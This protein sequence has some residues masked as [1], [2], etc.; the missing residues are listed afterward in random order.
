MTPAVPR[1]LSA[2]SSDPG[3]V[4]D[5]NE[6][7][8]Y[9]DDTRGFFVVIDGMGGHQA[10]EQA[11]DIALERIRSRLE[12]QT[13]NAEQRL[14][15]AITLANNAIFEAAH[16]REEWHGMAC[17]LTA[18]IVENGHV[19]IG[20]VGDSR[21][22]KIR[23]G[24]IEKMT[25]DHSPVGEREDRGEISEAEAM[26]HPRRNEVYR[27]V[28]SM[29]HAPDD[30]DFIEIARIPFE[31]DSAL[32][33]CSDGLSDV[34]SSAAI[35]RIVEAN[36]GDRW[37]A[38]RSLIAAANEDGKDNISAILVE[39]AEYASGKPIRKDIE[40]TG[41]I[42][43]VR[44]DA[45]YRR[46]GYFAAGLILGGLLV[47]A[48]QSMYPPP[49]L[50]HMPQSFVVAEDGTIAAALIKAQAGDTVLLPP[51][52][53]R[54]LVE[55]KAGVDLIAQKPRETILEGSLVA[56]SI[57]HVR[58]ENLQIRAG[59]IGIDIRNSDVQI[60]RCEVSGAHTAGVRFSGNSSGSLIASVIRNNPGAGIAIEDASAPAIEH[61]T[62]TANG[63]E[64][65]A[66]H[67]GLFIHTTGHPAVHGN[68]F[69]GNGAEAI[70]L[71][72]ADEGIVQRNYFTPAS[73][74]DKRKPFRIL[75]PEGRP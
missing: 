55:L 62:V 1:Y 13:D 3:S 71:A 54:E 41:R 59:T 24:K 10:G 74:A 42:I 17:V 25:H 67:P 38:V 14:R 51:G 46:I 66:P 8:V 15:E 48:V 58:V 18:A 32:L 56:N 52:T 21:L 20:Q 43:P 64:P 47:F 72:S 36:A 22:Y 26:R 50:P 9:A 53:F 65:G 37:A 30:E 69:S 29:E 28:G 73:K 40:D 75:P 16:E 49:P 33:L 45:W 60:S 68:Y 2:A 23:R 7:R 39:G 57:N 31:A 70:W 63:A 6:D 5:N 35:L 11:A 12:R 4:R 61:N 27:D 34:L 19:T 44:R